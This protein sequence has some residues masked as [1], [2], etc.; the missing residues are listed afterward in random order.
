MKNLKLT[1][2]VL[3]CMLFAS[4]FTAMADDID[5]ANGDGNVQDI[6]AA[7]IDD[8]VPMAFIAIIGMSYLLIGKKSI[9]N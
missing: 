5:N 6:P 7:P 4:P 3:F 9:N 8:Y 1:K 2:I